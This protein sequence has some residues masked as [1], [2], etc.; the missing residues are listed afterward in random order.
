MGKTLEMDQWKKDFCRRLKEARLTAGMR[1]EDAARKIG[2]AA[3]SLTNWEHGKVMPS[4]ETVSRLC[5]AYR[6]EPR[7]VIGRELS[8]EDYGRML[9]KPPESRSNMEKMALAFAGSYGGIQHIRTEQEIEEDM[10][11]N[12]FQALS[13]ELRNVILSIMRGLL[14]DQKKDD[15]DIRRE[16]DI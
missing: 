8:Q 3:T 13:E 15:P 14:Q 10:L 9:A 4:P 12:T 7:M 5:Q 16:E 1:Q 2:V 11:L 6:V